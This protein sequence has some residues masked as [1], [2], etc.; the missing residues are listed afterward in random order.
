MN[1]RARTSGGA[2]TRTVAMHNTGLILAALRGARPMS[3]REIADATGLSRATANRLTEDLLGRGMLVEEHT[4]A[5]T[6][7][8][9]ARM[10]R[11][12][13]SQ[14]GVLAVDLGPRKT[15]AAV[16]DIDGV[17]VYREVRPTGGPGG[18]AGSKEVLEGL[19]LFC[20]EM[21]S[22][23]EGRCR[24][25]AA[26]VSVPG[27]V[28]S[29]TGLV[30]FAPAVGWWAMPLADHLGKALGIPVLAENDVNLLV[31]GEHRRGAAVG[32][33]NVVAVSIGTGVGAGLILGGRLYR[34]WRG[35]AGEIGY[36]LVEPDSVHKTWPEFGD[37][38][39]RLGRGA[40]ERAAR[41]GGFADIESFMRAGWSGDRE[42]N[43]MID[44]LTDVLALAVAG[45]SVLVSP[46]MI[47]IGGQTGRA[48]DRMIARVA[49]RLP[50]RI[51]TVPRVVPARLQDAEL[52]GA[53][54][55]AMDQVALR[56][57]ILRG[58]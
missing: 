32:V 53:A 33:D 57:S 51:P 56:E 45:I 3:L 17:P 50:A 35:G 9:P 5:Q 26:A 4:V 40:L 19:E 58:A 52:I 15:T 11:Y 2:T 20:R 28:R 18:A 39:S 14:R 34:G 13:G 47:L 55:L 25:Q 1:P 49:E 27:V 6:G 48:A 10:F 21:V 36:M 42:A 30:D 7:G 8:R 24:V 38:E 54:E 43:R 41:G 22:N 29:D 23:V 46:E 12:D 31:L 37:L 16:F 44:R